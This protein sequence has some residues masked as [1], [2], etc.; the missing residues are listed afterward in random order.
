MLFEV[1]VKPAP[2]R[3]W[4]CACRDGRR[5]D[6]GHEDL[7][8]EVTLDCFGLATFLASQRVT[9]PKYVGD[10]DK[11]IAFF[12]HATGAI[13]GSGSSGEHAKNQPLKP[14]PNSN[15]LS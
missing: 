15:R 1:A 6:G 10:Y 5:P 11:Q 2:R 14:S 9:G 13:L 8:A 7:E 4:R 12:S 3:K